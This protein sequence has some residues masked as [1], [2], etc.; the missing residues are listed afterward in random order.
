MPEIFEV[1]VNGIGVPTNQN[2]QKNQSDQASGFRDREHVLN[3]LAKLQSARIHEG[4]QHDKQNADKLRGGKG[5]R[6][7]RSDSDR[8]DDIVVDGSLRP[9]DAEKLCEPDRDR[10]DGP[11][12]NHEEE[13]PAIEKAPQR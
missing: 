6:V 12:L 11:R 3:N 7:T 9:K 2:A 4:E 5:D 10:R 1:D 13:R 8:S